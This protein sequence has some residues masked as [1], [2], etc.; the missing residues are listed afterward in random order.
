MDGMVKKIFVLVILVLTFGLAL[1][2]I[3]APKKDYSENE[4]RYLEKFPEPSLEN[5]T[6]ASFMKDTE[7]FVSDHFILRDIFMTIKTGYERATGRNRVNNIYL[8]KD[9]GVVR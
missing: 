1:A 5:I 6:D 4:N 9:A 2:T 3:I 7:T 8:C